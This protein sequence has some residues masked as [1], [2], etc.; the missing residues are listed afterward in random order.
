MIRAG[1][2]CRILASLLYVTKAPFRIAEDPSVSVIREAICPAVQL[3]IITEKRIDGS[4]IIL[5]YRLIQAVNNGAS[6]SQLHEVEHLENGVKKAGQPEIFRADHMD[7][8]R[9]DDKREKNARD[10]INLPDHNISFRIP[11]IKIY[12]VYLILCNINLNNIR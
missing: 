12:P 1:T 10:F 6:R 3:S 2:P 7:D 5:C 8:H 4:V 11:V 9:A